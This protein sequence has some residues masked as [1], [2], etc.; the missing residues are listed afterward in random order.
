MNRV[1][2]ADGPRRAIRTAWLRSAAL[3]GVAA[4]LALPG[5]ALPMAPASA[6]PSA[7]ATPASVTSITINGKRPGAVFDG[8]G[9][10]SGGGGNSRYLIDYPAPARSRILNFLFGPGGAHLQILKLEIG[11]D[12]NTSDGS[13]PSIEHARG[14]VDCR[15]GYEWWLAEQ[16]LA[17]DPYVKLYAL[18]WAAP[19]WVG[20]VWSK[21]DVR[22]VIQW[23]NCAKSHHLKISYLGGWNEHGY[24]ITWYE[25]MRRA[26]DLHGY[27]S[28]KIVAADS[29]VTTAWQ[30]ARAAATHPAFRAAVSALGA[31]DTCGYPTTGFRCTVTA[32]ARHLGFPLWESELGALDANAGAPAVVRSIDNGYIQAG[33]TGY[34]EWP[35]IDSMP[36]GLWHENGGLVTADQPWSGSYHVNRVVWAIAQTTQFTRPGWRHVNGADGTIGDSGSYDA[37][38]SPRGHDWSLVTENTSH[39]ANQSISPQAIDVRLTGG[40]ATGAVHVWATNLWSGDPSAWFVEQPD[41]KPAGG[42]FSYTVPA[43]YVV[44]FT[45]TSGQSHDTATA[46]PPRPMTPPYLATRDLSNEA[47][48]LASQEGAFVYRRCRGG[49]GGRCLEQLAGRVPV[50]WLAP[51][52]GTPTPY[53][54]VGG[55]G[56]HDYTVRTRILFTNPAGRASLI[57]RFGTQGR[58]TRL[59]T[60]YEAS[61]SADGRWQITRDSDV[62]DPVVLASG[63]LAA[64]K[65]GTW[66]TISFGLHGSTLRFGVNGTAVGRVADKRYASGLAGIGSNWDLVRFDGLTVR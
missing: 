19:G 61:L 16:A 55:P 26:L 60:G 29:P 3:P 24:N 42:A 23:L 27:R 59:F 25:N 39:F 62:A 20:T 2:S 1:E 50:W 51:Y 17:R 64:I 11:G 28:I 47:W 43:G 45:S 30:V 8:I 63:R 7:P 33:V 46:R 9:A 14:Q 31:H 22:Y 10:I 56:W 32:T 38:E 13:E 36:A 65:P 6:L 40:L 21:A 49:T 37:Y 15:S 54:I 58:D 44:S 41:I 66:Q 52:S 5:S 4:V 34:V 48:G 57:G 18:Q 35:L 12:A 53:A